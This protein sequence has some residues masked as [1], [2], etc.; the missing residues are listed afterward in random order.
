MVNSVGKEFVIDNV[1]PT[2]TIA[3]IKQK[4]APFITKNKQLF[5]Y[6]LRKLEDDKTLGDYFI[7]DSAAIMYNFDNLEKYRVDR[8]QKN[9]WTDDFIMRQI[10]GLNLEG[11]FEANCMEIKKLE[12]VDFDPETEEAVASFDQSIR[13]ISGE[14]FLGN[15]S[16]HINFKLLK[17]MNVT[18]ILIAHES[19]KPLYPKFFKYLILEATDA[20]KQ[21]IIDYFLDIF[22]Y[23]DEARREGGSVLVHCTAGKSRSAALVCGYIMYKKKIPFET[24]LKYVQRRRPIANPNPGFQKQLKYFYQMNFDLSMKN[25][26]VEAFFKSLTF[27]GRLIKNFQLAPRPPP[28]PLPVF[29]VTPSGGDGG[30]WTQK[31]VLLVAQKAFHSKKFVNNP[32]AD[33]SG[34]DL[35]GINLSNANL[36]FANLSKCNLQ[37]SNLENANLRFANLTDSDLSYSKL[38]S[39]DMAETN[40]NGAKFIESVGLGDRFKIKWGITEEHS[41]VDHWSSLVDYKIHPQEGK[42]VI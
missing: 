17:E 36:K 27:K 22:Q 14:L 35:R 5:Y 19:L 28:P 40:C 9:G 32:S 20:D 29:Y 39:T 7:E 18:H 10:L 12:S 23:I 33:W 31:E 1:Q 30:R 21:N 16:S 4:L 42:K 8:V 15:I 6:E 11:N 25:P 3:S 13:P 34:M 24:A 26:E 38:V 37:Y 2:D 41:K